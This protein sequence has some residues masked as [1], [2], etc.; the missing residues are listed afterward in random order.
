MWSFGLFRRA[1]AASLLALGAAAVTAAAP[2]C[3]SKTGSVTS[4]CPAGQT[5]Q[6]RLTLFH[7]A[8]MHSR[9]LPYDLLITQVDEGLGLGRTGQLASVGGAA[10]MSTILQRERARAGRSLHLSGGDC[11]QG[12][13]I[14]NF[15]SGQPEMQMQTNL[16]VDA[17]VIANHEFDR[18]PINAARQIQKWS[19]FAVLAA[20]YKFSDPALP[21]S[22]PLGSVVEPFTVFNLDGLK[23]GVI[24]MANLSSLT[25]IFD[26][27]NSSGILTLRTAGTAQL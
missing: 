8:D 27:P 9:L 17:M 23:V 11:F 14:F 21:S 2:G 10:R 18:G 26:Q 19:N 3:S 4:P 7:T 13:P 6:A 15:F 25:S 12:A 22:T 1:A 24:G 20:N 5:C 16:R